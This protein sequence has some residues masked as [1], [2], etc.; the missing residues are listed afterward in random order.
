MPLVLTKC[1]TNFF[2]LFWQLIY[3]AAIIVPAIQCNQELRVMNFCN[4]ITWRPCCSAVG[5][6]PLEVSK[7]ISN[8]RRQRQVCNTRNMGCSQMKTLELF[9]TRFRLW[10][11]A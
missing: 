6:S 2:Y 7:L 11:K 10:K 5:F 3:L 8:K 9:Q 1:T 4:Q